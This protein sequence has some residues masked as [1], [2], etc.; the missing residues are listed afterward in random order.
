MDLI[1]FW[2]STSPSAI[3]F[4]SRFTAMALCAK[5][6][7]K[8]VPKEPLSSGSM[9]SPVAFLCLICTWKASNS[10]AL[11]WG[12]VRHT[13][14]LEIDLLSFGDTLILWS[15]I[16]RWSWFFGAFNP[17]VRLLSRSSI[18]QWSRFFGAYNPSVIILRFASYFSPVIILRCSYLCFMF[19]SS[20]VLAFTKSFDL[21][22]NSFYGQTGMLWK[23]WMN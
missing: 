22:N 23:P 7:L 10:I 3:T 6:P 1:S 5:V 21:S 12:A 16:L 19:W 2:N 13:Y 17:S 14:F 15:S 8:T 11:V 4:S 20:N 18:L 9:K